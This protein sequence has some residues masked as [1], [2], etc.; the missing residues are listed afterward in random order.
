MR[1]T[2]FNA[3]G[4]LWLVSTNLLLTPLILSYLGQDRFAVWALFW[5]F[6]QYFLLLDLGVGS[7]VVKYFSEYES[8][9]DLVSINRVLASALFFYLALGSI[10]VMLLWPVV[11]WIEHEQ[12]GSGDA[13]QL[14][15]AAAG[16]RHVVRALRL[17]LLDR[18]RNGGSR[19][20]AIR[21]GSRMERI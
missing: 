2:A 20:P 10:A 1:N 11:G 18:L 19:G 13:V 3:M 5:S 14:R 8:K 17:P 4:R 16:L 9:G 12:A 6:T 7:S 15:A 21:R